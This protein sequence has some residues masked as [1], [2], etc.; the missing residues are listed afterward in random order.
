MQWRPITDRVAVAAM[1]L[2]CCASLWEVVSDVDAVVHRPNWIPP[3]D[4]A[5]DQ[6]QKVV[7]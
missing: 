5:L 3:V 6:A 7:R 1:C 4:R 2:F